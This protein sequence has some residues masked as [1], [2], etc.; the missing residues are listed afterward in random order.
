LAD[1]SKRPDPTRPPA[2][3]PI[4]PR[5]LVCLGL[6]QIVGWGALHYLIGLF[7]AP[8]GAELGWSPT[9]VQGGF[10][11]A[12]VV[13]G[14]C[15]WRVGAWIDRHGGR[16][17]MMTGCWLGAAGCLLLATMHGRAQFALAWVFIGL[18]MRLALYD[19]AFASLAYVAGTGARRHLAF[20]TLFGGFASTVFWPLGQALIHTLGWRGALVAYAGLLAAASLLHLALPAS[21]QA[22][23]GGADAAAPAD[24]TAPAAPV[25]P[26][27]GAYRL[28]AV[29]ALTVLFLQTAMA[30]Q[31]LELLHGR[32]WDA[33]TT[34]TL[35]M[36]LGVGQ[37][38][39]RFSVAAWA[40]R[41][42]AVKLNLM[43]GAYVF[44]AFVL[45]LVAGRTLWGAGAFAFLYGAGNGLATITRGAIPLVIFEA[46]AYGRTV[47]AVL[48][49]ALAAAAVAP[50]AFAFIIARAGHDAA[51]V[52]AL[53]ISAATLCASWLLHR[54]VLQARLQAA[55]A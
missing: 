5:L 45:Y 4:T 47:G 54:R 37:F 15:S 25:V 21:R 1:V 14:L 7:A 43:P 13:M 11:L 31:F 49:P 17:A 28:F 36:L 29:I 16:T 40:H 32:G 53:G 51:A 8:I 27:P 33:A 52:T 23:G 19:A 12:L 3:S 34:V 44:L 48:R 2:A 35:S 46:G 6:S 26:V 24:S 22:R 55:A 30:A 38:A 20:V 10:S 42:D 9:F 41:V 18:A 39:G 50:M